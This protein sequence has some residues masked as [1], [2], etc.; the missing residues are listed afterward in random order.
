[1]KA[2]RRNSEG[3]TGILAAAA[4]LLRALAGRREAV[5]Q[6]GT[7][8]RDIETRFERLVESVTDYAIF[9]LDREGRVTSWNAGA[10]RI[11]GYAAEEILGRSF[12]CFFTEEDRR[13][14]APARALAE[15]ARD[16]ALRIRRLASA[17]RRHPVLGQRRGGCDRR[18][19]RRGWSRSPRSPATSPSERGIGAPAGA[20]AEDGG[21]RPA[22][23]RH[24]ARLQQPV[25]SGVGQSRAGPCR[26]WRRAAPRAST[27]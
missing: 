24:R 3:P 4:G 7:A 15:A 5:E 23:R 25:A 8:A 16:R 11:K 21:D 10:A 27:A 17:Q 19:R 18:R 6:P 20:G 13:A 22:H 14:G 9:M 26:A 2:P 12:E 1:M